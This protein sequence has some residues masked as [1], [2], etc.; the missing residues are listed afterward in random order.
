MATIQFF[1]LSNKGVSTYA[2]YL[3]GNGY[4]L[5]QYASKFVYLHPDMI[6]KSKIP[7]SFFPPQPVPSFGC[8]SGSNI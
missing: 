6:L 3:K 1:K 4:P 2:V 5:V 8:L 7:Y